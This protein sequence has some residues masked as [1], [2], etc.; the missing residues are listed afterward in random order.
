MIKYPYYNNHCL[1]FNQNLELINFNMLLEDNKNLFEYQSFMLLI[2]ELLLKLQLLDCFNFSID[3]NVLFH[4]IN[5]YP[6]FFFMKI[7][8]NEIKFNN[9]MDNL[10]NQFKKI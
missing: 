2:Y 8:V 4:E 1:F 6:E 5:N 9:D 7:L 3:E 10:S